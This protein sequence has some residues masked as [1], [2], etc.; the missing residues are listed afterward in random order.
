MWIATRNGE[1]SD[2]NMW[3]HIGQD[4]RGDCHI[5]VGNNVCNYVW[6][7]CIGRPSS[8]QEL[9]DKVRELAVEASTKLL[10]QKESECQE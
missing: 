1:F 8:E 4:E 5:S 6:G 3:Y 2:L 7:S 9:N 10:P